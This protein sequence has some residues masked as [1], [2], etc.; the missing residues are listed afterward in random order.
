MWLVRVLDPRPNGAALV[1]AAWFLDA[2]ALVV[3]G[4]R[5]GSRT[6]RTAGAAVMALTMGKLFVFDMS[7]VDAGWRIVVFL[8]FGAVLLA[9]GYAFPSLWRD[10]ASPERHD[11]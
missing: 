1:T 8:A 7:E 11:T 6:V 10:E 2:V 3:A 9:L 5:G 4:L